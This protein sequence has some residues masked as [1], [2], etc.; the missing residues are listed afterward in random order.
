MVL[1]TLAAFLTL[2]SAAAAQD[3][4]PL[5]IDEKAGQV[6]FG[7]KTLKTDVHPQLKGE[8]EY[9]ITLPK[10]KSYESCFESAAI[11]VLELYHGLQKIGAKPGKYATGE[12]PAT[13][14]KLKMWVEWK[15]G[16]KA[17]K[18]PIE[19]FIVDEEA[20]KPMENVQW[21]FS[22]SKGGFVPELDNMGLMVLSTKNLMGLYQGDP[23]TLFTNPAPLMTGHRYKANKALLPKEGTPVKIVIEPV[24]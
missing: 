6:S 22:G 14:H 17:R 12:E 19:S 16:E 2:A 10:G 4:E 5:K 7:A 18:E 11:D 23:T 1:S 3:L 8:I 15:D 21:L 13:G 9:V 24:K 20:K